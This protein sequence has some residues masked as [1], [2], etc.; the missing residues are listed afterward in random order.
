MSADNVVT[1][2]DTTFR[3]GVQSLWAMKQTYGMVDGVGKLIDEAGFASTEVYKSHAGANYEVLLN[4]EDK[5]R[6]KQRHRHLC[7]DRKFFV[8]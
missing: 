4:N 7:H 2:H 1:F 5:L 3:D 8:P 6:S